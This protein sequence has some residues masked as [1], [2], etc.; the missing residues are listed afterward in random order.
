MGI[1][2]ILVTGG[3][4]VGIVAFSAPVSSII[5]LPVA[6]G[7]TALSFVGV[8]IKER[9]QIKAKKQDE[10]RVLAM[11]KLNTITD[12]VSYH[13]WDG[14]IDE[15]EFSSIMVEV[16]KYQ[17]LKS[18]IRSKRAQQITNFTLSDTIKKEVQEQVR[19]KLKTLL[20]KD[21]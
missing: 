20:L 13:M 5:A 6:A 1:N 4:R 19:G 15:R 2:I 16:D 8:A 14:R 11:A 7:L 3:L 10:I 17:K 12:R 18:D 21:I 9:L